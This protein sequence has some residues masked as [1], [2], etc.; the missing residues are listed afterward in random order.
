MTKDTRDH[1]TA[2]LAFMVFV[3]LLGLLFV[4]IPDGN[5]EIL[6]LLAGAIIGAFGTA[7]SYWL[8]SSD[9]S[10]QKTALMS[11]ADKT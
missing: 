5:K 6:Y 11:K 3:L 10:A 1:V 8:G 2:G 7:V 4:E 9:G